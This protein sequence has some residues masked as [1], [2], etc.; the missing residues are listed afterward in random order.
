MLDG[1]K[2]DFIDDGIFNANYSNDDF[3]DSRD[4]DDNLDDVIVISIAIN[5]SIIGM[6]VVI[7]MTKSS[8]DWCQLG[9]REKVKTHE[10]PIP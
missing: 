4:R 1:D 8:G 9:G 7:I 10:Q 5:N 3:L 6:M 2:V